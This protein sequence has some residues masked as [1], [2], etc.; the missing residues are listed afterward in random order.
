MSP[1][2]ELCL[3]GIDPKKKK[4]EQIVY[5]RSLPGSSPPFVLSN[6]YSLA[7]DKDGVIWLARDKYISY[8]ISSEKKLMPD[9]E[10]GCLK[11]WLLGIDPKKKESEQIVYDRCFDFK[12]FYFYDIDT[13]TASIAI[14][15]DGEIWILGTT[16]DCSSTFP[17]GGSNIWLL[18]INPKKHESEQIVCDKCIGNDRHETAL[19]LT[20]DTN[21][22]LCILGRHRG[23]YIGDKRNRTNDSIW[24]VA[25]D[26]KQ[27]EDKQFIYHYNFGEDVSKA[28]IAVGKDG[29]IWVLKCALN[30]RNI[31]LV[32]IKDKRVVYNHI[33]ELNFNLAHASL[34]VNADGI[35]WI[36]VQPDLMKLGRDARYE[37]LLLGVDPKEKKGEQI[38][39]NRSYGRK[40]FIAEV[41]FLQTP[42]VQI[43]INGTLWMLGEVPVSYDNGTEW[44]TQSQDYENMRLSTK[45][46]SDKNLWLLGVKTP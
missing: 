21:G 13:K 30:E 6:H 38:V 43:D 3:L 31:S 11:P 45:I 42:S 20:I 15:A 7:I 8:S 12:D 36:A 28:S 44:L 1:P 41:D 33:F 22:N 2:P 32:G 24:L 39:Y 35:V 10:S 19:A 4:G 5:K 46:T 14:G 17:I 37:V 18:G 34:T 23:Q 16:L 25:I 40:N 27:S 29:T 9:L 26:P